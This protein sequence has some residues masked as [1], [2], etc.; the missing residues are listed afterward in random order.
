M[1]K[2]YRIKKSEEIAAICKRKVKVY[3][4]YFY[5]YY[6]KGINHIR[7]AFSTSKKYGHAYERNYARRVLRNVI[8]Q[9]M[10]LDLPIDMVIV[11][12]N[13]FKEANFDEIT[14]AFKMCLKI[15]L[16]N[17]NKEEKT[18]EIN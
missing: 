6:Q 15:L 4:K 3:S 16:K 9:N 18:N 8:Y 1:K 14:N 11:V 12:K 13:E 2:E 17:I 10:D 7:V 5:I